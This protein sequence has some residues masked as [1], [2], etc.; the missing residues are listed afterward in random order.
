VPEAGESMRRLDARPVPETS[1]E[2]RLVT[3]VRNEMLRLPWFLEHHRSIGVQRFF[4]IDNGSDDGSTEFLRDQPD[5]HVYYTTED[6]REKRRAWKQEILTNHCV[7]C[8]TLHVDADELFVF[9][10]MERVGLSDFCRHLDD[11]ESRGVHAT[12]VDMYADGP[13]RDTRYD[14]SASP[15]AACP[16]FD[17]DTYRLYFKPSPGNRAPNYLV[18]GGPRERLFFGS[19]RLGKG[20]DESLCRWLYDIHRTVAPAF[21]RWPPLARLL[22]HLPSIAR[23][24]RAPHMSKIPLVRWGPDLELENP[25]LH[26]VRPAIPLSDC[27]AG[28]LHFKYL[29]DFGTRVDE[30]VE[31][32]QHYGFAAQYER[33][34]DALEADPDIA[35]YGPWSQRF[36]SS[37]SLIEAGLMRRSDGFAAF[38]SRLTTRA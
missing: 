18:L 6:Y 19:G 38:V 3:Q 23:A 5:V 1:C 35:A 28:I 8:W 14:P 24:R 25:A 31:R 34:R 30:A 10:E 21:N 22:R 36:E 33:Y 29:Y 13:F 27:W 17:A 15:L 9:P 4:V 37:E 26:Y 12:L 20:W 32:K 16:Y 2:I 11:T 7:G